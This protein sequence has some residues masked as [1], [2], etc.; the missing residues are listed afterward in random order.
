MDC[1]TGL[2]CFLVSS[3][4]QP[5]RDTG[6]RLQTGKERVG[7]FIPLTPYLLGCRLNSLCSSI[8]GHCCCQA[9][10]SHGHPL[11]VPETI[12]SLWS[13][14]FMPGEC[15]GSQLLPAMG[16]FSP[17]VSLNLAHTFVTSP[18]SKLS[19]IT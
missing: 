4:V 1:I 16:Y 7:V 5:V 2:L 9:A 12:P 3:S 19:P 14:Y 15:Y 18:F 8:K 6:R 17:M 11:L 10:L 13:C